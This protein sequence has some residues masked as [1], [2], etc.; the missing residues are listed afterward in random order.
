MAAKIIDDTILQDIAEAIQ[1]KDGGSKMRIGDMAA[2][3][4]AIETQN[5]MAVTNMIINRNISTIESDVS[6]VGYSSFSRCI[7]LTSA[8][9]SEAQSLGISSFEKCSRLTNI[10]IPKAAA[11]DEKCFYDCIRLRRIFLRSVIQISV[12]SF[13]ACSALTTVVM[14]TR[15]Y[16]SNSDAFLNSNNA[17]IYV[18]PDDINWYREQTNWS[19]YSNRIK[20]VSELT[21][22]DLTWYQQQ[23]TKYPLS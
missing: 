6:S 14:G 8:I 15:A 13:R 18:Q 20:S 3:I 5:N 22:D 16:M 9:F 10:E 12:Q 4:L 21:G 7:N 2:R 11:I 23:L 19:A 17:I 1:E